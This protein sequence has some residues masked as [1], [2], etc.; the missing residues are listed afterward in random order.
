[1]KNKYKNWKSATK[2]NCHREDVI[3]KNWWQSSKCANRDRGWIFC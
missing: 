1:M 2:E 3:E